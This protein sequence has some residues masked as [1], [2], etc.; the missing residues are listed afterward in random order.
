[1]SHEYTVMR[2]S[3]GGMDYLRNFVQER[4]V[5]ESVF[6]LSQLIKRRPKV[7]V[8]VEGKDEGVFVAN[9]AGFCKK[10]ARFCL[11]IVAEPFV[12]CKI[13]NLL[14]WDR[15]RAGCRGVNGRLRT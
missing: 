4:K 14:C 11:D 6:S 12:L 3:F 15:V 5:Y 8:I 13:G 10:W 9:G 2:Q 7:A 1:M